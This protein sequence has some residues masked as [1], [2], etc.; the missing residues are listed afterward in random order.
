MPERT[1][2]VNHK[3][4]PFITKPQP[5][6]VV[7]GGRGSGKSIGLSDMAIMRMER[8]G[9]D[10]Y[11]LREYQESIADSVHRTFSRSITDRFQL[12]GWDIQENKILSPSG[13]RTTYKGAAR[14]PNNIQGAEDYKLSIFSE[15]HTASQASIDKLLPTILRKPGAQCWFDANP[16][17]SEDPFSQRFITPYQDELDRNGFYEDDL[18]YIVVVNWRDNP[19]WNAEQEALRAW[20]YTNLSRAKY[21]W[22][23]EGRF[24]D[25]V[26]NALI[27]SEWFDACIDAHIKLGI[28]PQ[29][30][31]MAAHDPSDEGPDSKGYAQRHGIVVT[32]VQEMTTG[33][34]N[35]GGDWATGLA[36]SAGVDAFTWDCDGMGVGLSRQV[37]NAFNG[38]RVS[39]TMFKGS[40]GVDHPAQVY[41][42]QEGQPIQDRKTW[43]DVARN[44]RAQYYLKLRDRCFKT[45]RAV[46][47][48]EYANPEELISF[49]STIGSLYK[50]RSELC[51]MPIKPNGNG[52]LEL[53]T[54]DVMKTKFKQSSPNLADS[55]MML[56]REPQILAA[57]PVIPQP[58]R[59]IGRR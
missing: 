57:T 58:L 46:Q 10:V 3:L 33:N 31:K 52:K 56:M 20:D 17:S 22:I 9:I 48:G 38:T 18:H 26:E 55:V 16:Q 37:G 32:D 36:I 51:R 24:N 11:C 35:D 27:M 42:P 12:E 15:A 41:D 45:F 53:Y 1:L 23:W 19:W 30:A 21:D 34:I 49:S 40:E 29:G 59:P 50:L 28:K 25:S 8:E 54:K 14:N 2:N 43:A 47:C 39:T 5:I 6:K 4:L 7:V 13:G 44:K